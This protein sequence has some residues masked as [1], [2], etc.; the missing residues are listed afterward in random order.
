[1]RFSVFTLCLCGLLLMNLP[2][3]QRS[4]SLPTGKVE[5]SVTYRG[6]PLKN[7][8]AS[9]ESTPP[10]YG[11]IADIKEGKFVVN[12]DVVLGSYVVT[13]LPQYAAPGKE[14][15]PENVVAIPAKYQNEKTSGLTAD[16]SS[17]WNQFTFNLK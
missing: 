6:K 17:G 2:G 1:M 7:G 12:G 11:A 8:Y 10:G 13:I 16:V 9:F 5:G 15:K 14:L 3:C 4:T